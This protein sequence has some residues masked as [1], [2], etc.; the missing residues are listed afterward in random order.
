VHLDCHI[1]KGIQDSS[2]VVSGQFRFAS[3]EA[4]NWFGRAV[5]RLY[6]WAM[7]DMDVQYQ[8][9][10]PAGPKII[11]ANHPTTIDPFFLLTLVSGPMSI[12]V[13][14]MCFKAPV[15][16]RYLRLAGHVPVVSGNGRAAFEEARQLLQAGR[17]I[18]IFTEGALSPIEG[19][20]GFHK[21]RTG[22]ARLALSTG[23]PVIPVGIHLHREGIRYVDTRLD[24]VS[25]VARW[26]LRGPYAMTIGQALRFEGDVEDR[27]RVR[28]ISD[29]IM[30]RIASLSHE[31]ARRLQASR[32]LVP[33]LENAVGKLRARPR[34]ALER[35]T[36]LQKKVTY[37]NLACPPG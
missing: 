33:A 1:N 3:D 8:A 28:A 10:L 22:T 7:L 25:A 30:R 24:D 11:A 31:S 32:R 20:I 23:A 19:G 6:T 34:P 35:P 37:R 2:W 36:S 5:M 15:F 14:G 21:P 4:F 27:D 12:L 18:G 9:P 16:G 29:R 13:T 26:Y 17:T